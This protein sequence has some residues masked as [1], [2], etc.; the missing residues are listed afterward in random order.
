MP[1]SATSGMGQSC[2]NHAYE[3]F[4]PVTATARMP[5]LVAA[6]AKP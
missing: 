3:P 2:W 1:V 5:L 6:S 4:P